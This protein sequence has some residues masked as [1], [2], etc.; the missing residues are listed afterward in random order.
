VI[1]AGFDHVSLD[2]PP[3]QT[4]FNSLPPSPSSTFAD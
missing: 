4:V 3:L 1:I 2:Y